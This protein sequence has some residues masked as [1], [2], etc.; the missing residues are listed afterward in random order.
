MPRSAFSLH[1]SSSCAVL[2]T[3]GLALSSS[4]S[5]RLSL[6]GPSS[7]TSCSWRPF[8]MPPPP[9]AAY[10]N[11][12]VTKQGLLQADTKTRAGW[13]AAGRQVRTSIGHWLPH[14]LTAALKDS[15]SLSELQ[16]FSASKWSFSPPSPTPPPQKVASLRPQPENWLRGLC[17]LQYEKKWEVQGG[18]DS[19]IFPL[20]QGRQHSLAEQLPEQRSAVL[21]SSFVHISLTF[22]RVTVIT[23]HVEASYSLPRVLMCRPKATG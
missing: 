4:L 17:W 21:T 11:G 7:S 10:L 18:T 16:L 22:C 14:F 20:P 13:V 23:P 6:L 15:R 9:S 8:L 12:A 2:T 1:S 19:L 3:R 5:A